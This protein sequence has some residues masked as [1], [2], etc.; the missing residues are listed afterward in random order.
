MM[1]NVSGMYSS[2]LNSYSSNSTPITSR[3]VDSLASA[4]QHFSDCY[5]M[6]TLDSLSRST[7]GRQVLHDRIQRDI[8]KPN[9]L[10]CYLYNENGV[11]EKYTIPTQQTF[12]G[13]KALYEHQA[14]DIVRSLDISVAEYELKHNSK[15]WFCR[16]ADKFR[17]FKFEFNLPSHFMKI[18]TGVKPTVNIAERAL[19]LSLKPYKKEVMALFEK[20]HQNK[21]FSFIIGSGIKKVDGK[22]FHAYVLEDV[23]LA[24]NK[25]VIKNKRGNEVKTYTVEEVLDKFK[26]IVGYFNEDLAKCPS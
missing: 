6:S 20:M 22:R 24:E 15:P 1:N 23:N 13:Y 21:D 5:L 9:M 14:N 18:F 19:N 10:N 8:D 25:V 16:L 2:R 7:N 12:Q 26:Y 4:Q 17:E 11:K 3:E